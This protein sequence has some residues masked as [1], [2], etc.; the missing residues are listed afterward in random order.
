MPHRSAQSL[1]LFVTIRIAALVAASFVASFAAMLEIE[2]PKDSA[3]DSQNVLKTLVGE[4]RTG[5]AYIVEEAGGLALRK[6]PWKLIAGKKTGKNPSGQLYNLESDI[7]EQVNVADKHPELVAE[8][9]RILAGIRE[10]G[11]R[12]Q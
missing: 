2:L 4:D 9:T 11:L 6:G 7:G 1:S 12:H 10:K 8:M 5:N 3:I